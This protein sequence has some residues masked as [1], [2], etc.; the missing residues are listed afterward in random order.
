M[1]RRVENLRMW[2]R[3]TLH[4]WFLRFPH[5]FEKM[6]REGAVTVRKKKETLALSSRGYIAQPLLSVVPTRRRYYRRSLEIMTEK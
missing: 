5:G 3:N 1:F 4:G 2:T 6:R